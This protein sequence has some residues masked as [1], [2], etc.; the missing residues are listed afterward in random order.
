MSKMRPPQEQKL[1]AANG[2]LSSPPS[3][4]RILSLLGTGANNISSMGSSSSTFTSNRHEQASLATCFLPSSQAS[5]GNRELCTGELED[6]GV[7]GP[8]HGI[9]N[10]N[11]DDS[12]TA[13]TH[14]RISPSSSSPARRKPKYGDQAK[15]V[16]A[17]SVGMFV[18]D[19]KT[20]LVKYNHNWHS[21]SAT[22]TRRVGRRRPATSSLPSTSSDD[23]ASTRSNKSGHNRAA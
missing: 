3:H 21:E 5:E 6:M 14:H 4:R 15:T 16:D 23:V 18:F 20:G 2:P 7:V 19:N 13:C 12:S 1:P 11:D 10:N 8:L 22:M 17:C 9:L